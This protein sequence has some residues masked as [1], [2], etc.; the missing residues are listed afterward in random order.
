M[1]VLITGAD[2]FIGSHLTEAF[3]RQGH[4]VRACA[5]QFIQPVGWREVPTANKIGSDLQ[6]KAV[7]PSLM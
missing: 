6:I 4:A 3:V 5:V 2:G 1:H 7:D